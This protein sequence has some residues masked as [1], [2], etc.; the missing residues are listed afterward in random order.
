MNE[1]TSGDKKVD[2]QES[3]EK[4]GEPERDSR[5]GGPVPG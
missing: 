1:R 2:E 3:S 4:S 5:G